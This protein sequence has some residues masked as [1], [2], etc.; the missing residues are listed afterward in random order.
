MHSSFC[1]VNLA[2]QV[3]PDWLIKMPTAGQREGSWAL[4]LRQ[5]PGGEDEEEGRSHYGGRCRDT[6]EGLL[7]K[8]WHRRNR[9][10]DI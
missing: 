2:S 9:A 6:R 3:I 4:G 1:G 5:D 8:E 10:N 7:E